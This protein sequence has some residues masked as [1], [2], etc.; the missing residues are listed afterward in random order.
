MFMEN[1]TKDLELMEQLYAAQDFEAFQRLGHKLRGAGLSYGFLKLG[2]LA[3][4]IEAAAK[5]QDLAQLRTL[6]DGIA[7]HLRNLEITYLH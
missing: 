1:R 2:E 7:T 4:S 3:G 5:A 6:I